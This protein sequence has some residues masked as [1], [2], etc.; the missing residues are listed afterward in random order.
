MTQRSLVLAAAV[1]LVGYGILLVTLA[2]T[3]SPEAAERLFSEEG[4][5][6]D[7]SAVLWFGLAL[8]ILLARPVALVKRIG[9]AVVAAALAAREE[10]WHKAFTA[11]SLFKT[12][13]YQMSGVPLVEKVIAGLVAVGLTITLIWLLVAG[14]RQ[15][16]GR[17]GWRRPWGWV[18]IAGV[19]IAPMLKI[20]DR[21][22]SILRQRF[23]LVLP[24]H[25]GT[26]MKALEEGFETVLPML[27]LL[28]LFLFLADKRD[29]DGQSLR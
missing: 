10:G 29:A 13:Y 27:F 6:E 2:N 14:G 4:W 5:F 23:D 22:P 21:A 26:V 20:I 24:E 3:M 11:D 15:L 1:L 7:L 17:G 12:D 8:V 19:G 9:M 28:A 16:F 25:V 18:A